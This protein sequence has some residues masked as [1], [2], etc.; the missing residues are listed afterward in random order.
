M[1]KTEFNI[2]FGAF[3]RAKREILGISQSQLAARIGN[4]Y[5]NISRLERGEISPTL[6]WCNLLADALEMELDELISQF[7]TS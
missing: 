2:K 5:Q 4:N 6:Y 3:V 1:N 7:L